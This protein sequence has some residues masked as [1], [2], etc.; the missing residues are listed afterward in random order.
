MLLVV[1]QLA[2]AQSPQAGINNVIAKID[3]FN[4]RLPAEK[5]YMQ[6][7]KPYYAVGDTIWFKAY[8]LNSDLNYSPLSSRL[9][10]ELVN[11]SSKVLRR[12]AVPMK[13][14]IT[15]GCIALDG[16]REGSVSIRAYTNW[17]RNFGQDYFF[18]R[19][20]YVSNPKKQT[21]LVNA[22]S[23]LADANNVNMAVKFTSLDNQTAG[24]RP[25]QLRVMDGKKTLFKG[26]A[27]TTSEGMLD[28]NFPL[29]DKTAVKNLVLVAQDKESKKQVAIPV[30]THRAKDVD[31]QFMPEGGY[32]VAGLPTHIGF[33]A[34]ADD[35]HGVNV[36]GKIV[37]AA[38][39]EIV[40]I[41]SVYKGMGTFDLA[42]QI[43]D[44]YTAK[45]N[46]PGGQ[47]KDVQLPAIKPSGTEIRIRN[48]ATRDSLD[49]SV[50][51]S[52]DLVKPGGAYY[53]VGQ[54]HGV[55]CFG[56]GVPSGKAFA[57]IHVSKKEFP[58]GVAH[59]TLLNTQGQALNE[60]LTFIDH[61]DHLKIKI[62]AGQQ[63][64]APRDS[65]PVK[66]SIN[67]ATGKPI[68]GSFSVAVTDDGQVK[69]DSTGNDNIMTRFLLSADLKGFVES[70]EYYFND[71][72]AAWQ[73]LD[74]LLLTQGWIG[75]DWTAIN[76]PPKPTFKP[77]YE[78][79]VNGYVGNLLNKPI[80]N[81]T[82]TLLATGKYNYIK[83]TTTN[84]QGRFV[85]NH[86]R[87][88]DSAV[89]VLQAQNKRH[90][91][92]NAGIT[93]DENI[94]PDVL[95]NNM[96]QAAP[97]YVN[98]DAAMLNYIKTNPIYHNE[99]DK[100]EYGPAGRM[101]KMV[102]IRNQ[103]IIKGSANLNDNGDADQV[104][105]E[106]AIENADK[107]PL[108][109]LLEQ[110]VKGY[111]TGYPPKGHDLN[112]YVRDRKVHF[113]FDGIDINRFYEPIDLGDGV[114]PTPNEYYNYVMSYL[115]YFTAEDIKGIEVQYSMKNTGRYN[116]QNLSTQDL[117]ANNPAGARGSAA[118]Y[119]EITTRSGAG[120]FARKANG[121]YVYKP[122][123]STLP[124]DFYRPR[125]TVKNIG[126]KFGD[127]RSTIHW[128]PAVVTDKNGEAT[129][130]FF[131]ADKPSTYTI[132]LEGGDLRG[133]IGHQ[134]QK[135]TVGSK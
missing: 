50:L 52:A 110:K 67:D 70:P 24:L 38:G 112:F 84:A 15:W 131:A 61:H 119:I 5:L 41:S 93:V 133:K 63:K 90:K 42:P 118:A 37:N 109:T 23:K 68:Q 17:M 8:L 132:T 77:E 19:A 88:V 91:V 100:A 117:L 29:P 57:T 92:I 47:T 130:S 28:V 54:A 58:T 105:D 20:F 128:E 98:S 72:K 14:G 108:S 7:D 120:P 32:M 33:K 125:Y 79:T 12:I 74:A 85:F 87:P 82:V 73:A 49:V 27:Q 51:L 80:T 16:V 43:G 111:H 75:Y 64:F 39:D 113:I 134:T 66:I 135:I 9:Y 4:N 60:R 122:L 76:T 26:A 69:A 36:T 45:L 25:M 129:L 65:I 6:F 94:A 124:K 101:L 83:D 34:V 126:S 114:P 21:W 3:T 81:A 115:E 22:G 95:K 106:Q 104:I 103:A 53:L 56:A 78:Y 30:S 127:L 40:A 99:L 13:I 96:P 18:N 59:F 48:I 86:F 107:T 44:V 71:D 121:I 89:F 97:W 11:D 10:V 2:K 1:A 35:G 116:V 102:T 31:V 55:V 62:T 46:L 123:K